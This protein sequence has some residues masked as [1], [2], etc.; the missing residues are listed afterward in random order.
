[1]IGASNTN[2]DASCMKTFEYNLSTGKYISDY[3]NDDDNT[4]SVHKE[5]VHKLNPLPKIE[6]HELFS[7]ELEGESI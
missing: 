6:T 4:K 3:T 7:I 1:M 5:G 2:G